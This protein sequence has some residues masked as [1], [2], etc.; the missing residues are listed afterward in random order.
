MLHL[1]QF[2]RN[3]GH[4]VT[5]T[6]AVIILSLAEPRQPKTRYDGM[7]NRTAVE[8]S[9]ASES[10]LILIFQSLANYSST[11]TRPVHIC[12]LLSL[13]KHTDS[14]TGSRRPNLNALFLLELQDHCS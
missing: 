12:K 5:A 14:S 6:N 1:A 3:Y 8:E 2:E 13:L 7:M 11:V 10:I 9:S 4:K